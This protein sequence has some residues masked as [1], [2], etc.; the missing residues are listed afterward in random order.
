MTDETYQKKRKA[1]DKEADSLLE[2]SKEMGTIQN[3][4]FR[5]LI[6]TIAAQFTAI[7]LI[8]SNALAGLLLVIAGILAFSLHRSYEKEA[9]GMM[10]EFIKRGDAL[11]K[12]HMRML[13]DKDPDA[14]LREIRK[15]LEEE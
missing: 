12:K 9:S 3:K 1:L 11:H 6:A 15:S 10:K 4:A 7:I 5:W 2:L 8:E 14:L 13:L